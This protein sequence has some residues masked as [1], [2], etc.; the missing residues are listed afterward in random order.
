MLQSK[1]Y[2]VRFFHI[3]SSTIVNIRDCARVT[4]GMG[5][6]EGSITGQ[7]KMLKRHSFLRDS[8]FKRLRKSTQIMIN[9]WTT[10]NVKY[11]CEN[12]HQDWKCKPRLQEGGG[13]TRLLGDHQWQN[14][15]ASSASD[16]QLQSVWKHQRYLH[17]HT[18]NAW[19]ASCWIKQILH[20]KYMADREMHL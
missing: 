18:R 1:C 10:A 12:S 16:T 8:H 13:E 2:L 20:I 9:A 17:K 5:F 11:K 4:K 19:Y 3:D 7:V 15:A 14:S 6:S